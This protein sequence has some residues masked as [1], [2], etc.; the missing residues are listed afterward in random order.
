MSEARILVVDDNPAVRESVAII[1]DGEEDLSVCGQSHCIDDALRQGKELQPDLAL[2][3][4]SLRAENGLDL[5]S[6]YREELPSIRSVVFSL[7]DEAFYIDAARE[8]GA[9]GYVI[10]GGSFQQMFHCLR[11]VLQG[12]SCFPDQVSS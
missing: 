5:V 11:R 12:H 7:H 3:D 1:I 2:V 9:Q 10:K 6:L 8:A 4:I